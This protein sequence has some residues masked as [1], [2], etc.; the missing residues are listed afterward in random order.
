MV[1]TRAADVHLRRWLV[2]STQFFKTN[3]SSI[4][5]KLKSKQINVFCDLENVQEIQKKHMIF[6]DWGRPQGNI[7]KKG[8]RDFPKSSLKIFG[9][10][11][12][13]KSNFDALDRL[14]GAFQVGFSERFRI[15]RYNKV[16]F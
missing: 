13:H 11:K 9:L 14:Y 7:N 2:H 4:L 15:N 5:L 16:S 3:T 12:I 10:L 1:I 8:H 6:Q